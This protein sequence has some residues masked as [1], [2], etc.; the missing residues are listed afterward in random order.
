[1]EF[2]AEQIA[3][4][5]NGEVIGNSQVKVNK[6][7]KIEEG[8]PQSISFLANMAYEH[9]L[10]TTEASIVIINRDLKLQKAVKETCTLIK[11]DNAYE[12]F[13]KLLETYQQMKGSKAG[14]E[15]PSFISESAKLGENCYVGAFAYIGENVTIGNNVKVYPN[16]YVGDNTIVGDNSILFAG[17]KLMDETVVGRNC[18]FH[19]GVVIGSDGFGFTPG[20]SNVYSKVPQ[21]G[22]VVIED[23]V[24][25]GGNTVIDRATMGSTVIRR[26]VKLDNLV[27]IAHNVVIGENSAIAGQVGIAGSAKIGKNCMMGGQVGVAGHLNIADGTKIAAQSGIGANIKVEGTVVQG[28]PAFYI[29]DYKRAYVGFKKLPEILD[30][31]DKLEKN[32]Q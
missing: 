25:I 24:E 7:S 23:D 19:A 28:S 18:I 16:T 27:H 21:I 5:L 11:V 29:G 8:E 3:G 1:M 12:C 6:L 32:N 20:E 26:G 31:L 4:I 13:A 14:I 22:N 15:Q 10:Y 9:Y 2:S 30:R 17:V